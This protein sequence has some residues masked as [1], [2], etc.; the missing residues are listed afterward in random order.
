MITM[1]MA[2][3]AACLAGDA[4]F[5]LMPHVR[6]FTKFLARLLAVPL[7]VSRVAEKTSSARTFSQRSRRAYPENMLGVTRASELF[8]LPS[9]LFFNFFNLFF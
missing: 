4:I 2:L 9:R 7:S 5:H 3:G 8:F 1:L 6:N